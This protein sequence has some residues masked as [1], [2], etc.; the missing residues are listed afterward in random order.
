M[1]LSGETGPVLSIGPVT[2]LDEGVYSVTV[3]DD[4]NEASA[5]FSLMVVAQLPAANH[6]ALMLKLYLYNSADM[7]LAFNHKFFKTVH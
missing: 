3:K 1:E 5:S 4:E 2:E 7:F 6:K